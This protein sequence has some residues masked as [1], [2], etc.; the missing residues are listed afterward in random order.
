MDWLIRKFAFVSRLITGY[1]N[2]VGEALRPLIPKKVVHLSYGVAIAYVIGDCFDKTIQTYQVRS[3]FDYHFLRDVFNFFSIFW[4]NSVQKRWEVI[5]YLPQPKRLAM[6]LHGKCLHPLLFPVLWSIASHGVLESSQ[7]ELNYLESHE[8]GYRPALDW[9]QFLSL[10]ARSI[11]LWT[12][13]WM[14]L[15]ENTFELELNN[16]TNERPMHSMH[17]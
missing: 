12:M 7:N 6:Y 13:P 4:K 5:K 16:Q 3:T 14:Q 10:F 17:K 8:N 11:P 2:E 1:A 9:Q 15:T